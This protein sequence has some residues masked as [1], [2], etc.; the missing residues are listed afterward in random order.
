MKDVRSVSQQEA[1]DAVIKA[2]RGT[3]I[4]PTGWGKTRV[5]VMLYNQL[6]KPKTLVVTSRQVLVAQ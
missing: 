4:L 2:R 1:V 6:N 5:G 3:I